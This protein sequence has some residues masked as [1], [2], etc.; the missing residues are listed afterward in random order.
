MDH[1]AEAVIGFVVARSDAPEFFELAEEVFDEM[2]PAIHRIVAHGLVR[3][4]GLGRDDGGGPA[5]VQ[6]G[7]QPIHI[8]GPVG[9]QRGQIEILDERRD[10]DAVVALTG[11][12]HKAHQIAECIDERHD[13]GGQAA[14]RAPDGLRLSPPLA[15]VPCWWTRTM[16]PSMSAYSKSGSPDKIWNRRSKMPFT[17]QRR[18]RLK[19]EFQFPK[20]GWRSRQGAPVRTIHST[21]SRKPRLSAPERPGSLAFPGSSGATRSHCASLNTLRSKADLRLSALNPICR[22]RGIPAAPMNVNRP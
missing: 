22:H 1:G 6:F 8:E 19:T 21:A 13:L 11:Q 2:T 5:R 16:V 14:A 17:A 10:P 15:P 18:K 3:S 4:I 20:A 7:P 12:E 9:Q